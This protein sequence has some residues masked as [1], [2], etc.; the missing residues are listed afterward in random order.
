MKKI[1]FLI[2]IYPLV[3]D[4]QTSNLILLDH[5]Y[6]DNLIT[7][8]DGESIFNEVW[9]LE[10]NNE[11]Y[12]VIG[13][14][15]GTHILKIEHN[16]LIEIDFVEGKYSGY[17]AIHRDYHDFNGYLY[18]VCDEN[19]S[20][21]QIMD[22]SF[23]PDSI[24]VVYDSDSLIIRAHNIFID[25]AKSK[26]Y[27]CAVSTPSQFHAMNVYDLS[28]PILP[29]LIYSYNEVGHVHDAYVYNDTWKICISF[30]FIIN[31]SNIHFI[32]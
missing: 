15:L 26:L 20:S 7:T 8:P 21:L 23:L 14:T 27:A 13:S 5:W 11:N 32:N 12:A 31:M 2:L 6:K 29:D 1:L 10:H 4:S 25:T 9:G 22:L 24:H 16:K 18:A 28:N 17:Q 19:L 3:I 30:K